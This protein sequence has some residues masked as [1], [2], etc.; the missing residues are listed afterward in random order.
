MDKGEG[1][2]QRK[3]VSGR[4]TGEEGRARKGGWTLFIDSNE[5]VAVGA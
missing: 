5:K 1:T 3:R 4:R 2:E